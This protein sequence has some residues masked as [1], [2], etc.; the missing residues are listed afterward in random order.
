MNDGNLVQ[1]CSVRY[2]MPRYEAFFAWWYGEYAYSAP[3]CKHRG[4]YP[5]HFFE[6]LYY[7]VTKDSRH[8][9]SITLHSTLVTCAIGGPCF[10]HS[11]NWSIASGSPQAKTCTVAS[12]MFFAY[13]VIPSAVAW[14]RVDS[15]NQTPCTRPLIRN[16]RHFISKR[17]SR[18][19]AA[20][21]N[22]A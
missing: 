7:R 6:Q 1:F 10:S 12:A 15:R 16:S 14:R 18:P 19:G 21:L 9:L 11:A 4:W 22:S 8:S 20:A 3:N 5:A 17:R 2:F 13:P